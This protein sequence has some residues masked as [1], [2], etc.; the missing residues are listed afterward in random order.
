MGAVYKG[1]QTGS[2]GD[3]GI[4]SFNGN[5]I[6]TGSSGGAFLSNSEYDADKIRKWSTQSREA[7]PWYQHQE[8][9]YNYRM[10]NVIAG[11]V[12]G[13][14]EYIE[15]HI[16]QKK[17]IYERYREGLADLPVAMNPLGED[18]VSNYWLS[19]ITIDPSAM[20]K[21]VRSEREKLYSHSKGKTCPDEILDVLAGFHIE[22][23]PI[24]KPMHLQAL[25]RGNGFVGVSG[26]RNKN[27]NIDEEKL[28]SVGA[29]IFER[30]LC[31]PSDIKMTAKQQDVVI[32][33]IHRCFE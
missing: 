27:I 13:Q 10:S 2:F 3:Y 31:L 15:E 8:L 19:C 16:A 29:D 32:D 24:W 9:G 1:R 23:R 6:I 28:D 30:G 5:K 14:M 18:S 17:A 22:G 4:I 12:R 11:V 26:R 21:N 7:A 20:C 25:Y 33:L